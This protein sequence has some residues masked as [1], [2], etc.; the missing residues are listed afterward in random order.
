MTRTPD[1]PK[2][3]A[4]RGSKHAHALTIES[5]T[6][7][8]WPHATPTLFA[9][10]MPCIDDF[11]RAGVTFPAEH[12]FAVPSGR[13]VP[14]TRYRRLSARIGIFTPSAPWVPTEQVFPYVSTAPTLGSAEVS[15]SGKGACCRSHSRTLNF[16]VLCL[17]ADPRLRTRRMASRDGG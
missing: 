14:T 6:N 9:P 8:G 13:G 4:S 12:N 5:Q 16:S 2:E 15:F 11:A 17:D 3:R 7:I 10:C 1:E